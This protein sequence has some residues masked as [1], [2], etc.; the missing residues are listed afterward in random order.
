MGHREGS[1][2]KLQSGLACA[3]A[4]G[5]LN[6]C[7]AQ[8]AKMTTQV[9]ENLYQG[10]LVS[11]P[12]PWAFEIGRAAII[13]VSDQ[14]LDMLSDPDKVLNLS[15]T[16]DKQEGSLRQVCERA[17]AAGQRTLILAFDHFFNQYRPGQDAPR[18]LTPD[19]DEYVGKM[20]AISK[21]AAGYGLGLELSLLSPLEVGPAFRAATGESG[22]WMHY[23]EGLRD[24]KTGRYDVQLWQQQQ[25]ATTRGR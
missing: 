25:C 17:K 16:F 1:C 3:V 9:P 20:A 23:R 24:P 15:M 10:Q 19:M 6:L 8:E 7:A 18:R 13:L 22:T 14:E 11:Y 4:L 5:L 2:R 12:G 21:F